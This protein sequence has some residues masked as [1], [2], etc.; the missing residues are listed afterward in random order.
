MNP[1]QLPFH[2]FKGTHQQVGQQHGEACR[3]LIHDHLDQCLSKLCR[4]ND[5]IDRSDIY[6]LALRYRP[7]VCAVAP[8]LDEEIDGLA[9]GAGISLAQAYVLQLRAELVATFKQGFAKEDCHEC[10]SF[11]VLS[12]RSA[13]QS[14]ILAHDMDLDVFYADLET[15]ME[16]HVEGE[17]SLFMVAAA[18]Q[19]SQLGLNQYGV[20]VCSNFLTCDGWRLGFPRYLI[21]R[22]VLQ[23][24]D[25]QSAAQRIYQLERASSRNYLIMDK[26]H[27][28]NIETTCD[29][30]AIIEPDDG[31]LFH[32]NHYCSPLMLE[33][34]RSEILLNSNTRLQRAQYLL[35]NKHS[36][37]FDDV[38]NLLR[39]RAELPH[40]I[41][42]HAQDI[43]DYPI[44][45]VASTIM[46][47]HELEISV[48]AYPP[49]KHEYVSYQLTC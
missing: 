2:V 8:E 7:Y 25:M 43:A 1:K 16:I 45:T 13:D 44:G 27:V 22:L 40:A 28:V 34:E 18:G 14:P 3:S 33:H 41:C 6:D 39:D 26:E 32:T 47:P 46:R 31:I 30:Y 24:H 17:P 19:I 20:A 4:I 23:E 9:Q 37:T 38:A 10:S 36:I 15:L 5:D 29:A 21:S 35:G 49:D 42:R 12:E 11:A 48:A